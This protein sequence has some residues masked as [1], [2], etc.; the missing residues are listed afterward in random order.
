MAVTPLE[1]QT[2]RGQDAEPWRQLATHYAE[3]GWL[4]E[5][6][7]A[8]RRAL[9][10]QPDH[11]AARTELVEILLA[12]G[13][14]YSAQQV[15]R[16]AAAA[17]GAERVWRARLDQLQAQ[18][19]V[20]R[21]T[22]VAPAYRCEDTLE[23]CLRAMQAQT[24]PVHELFVVDD[25]SPDRSAEIAR[26]LGVR[27]VAHTENRGLAATCNTALGQAS[28]E[29]LAKL[30]S[31][32]ELSPVWLERAMLAFD[33]PSVAGVGGCVTERYASTVPDRWRRVFMPQQ[34]GPRRLDDAP[35][36]FGADCIYRVAALQ[37]VG[38]WNTRYRNNFE[39]MDLSRRLK[40]AGYR[41][42]YEP[43]ARARHLRRD[44]LPDV[45]NN[46]W[47][48]YHAPA[49]DQGGYDSLT[50]AARLIARN[51]TLAEERLAHCLDHGSAA[52]LT[53][54]SFL[55]FYWLCLRDVRHVARRGRVSEEAASQ[56]G[57]GVFLLAREELGRAVALPPEVVERAVDDLK[58][59]AESA[60]GGPAE[61]A[62]GSPGLEASRPA[63]GP[64]PA[65]SGADA[66]Y[67]REFAR[68][69]FA[70]TLRPVHGV[71]LRVSVAALTA[72][73]RES[74]GSRPVV[75]FNPPVRREGARL[76]DEDAASR[77]LV[78]SRIEAAADRLLVSDCPRL[79]LAYAGNAI[80]PDE[81]TH[82]PM[83]DVIHAGEPDGV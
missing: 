59:C 18:W 53:Y 83:F 8:Y 24:Y 7:A 60:F 9:Q 43:L 6:E 27:V 40:A 72:E 80:A 3:R 42:V 26:G 64:T 75:W 70:R 39:D 10:F 36:L 15:L 46:F 73:E 77:W 81:E 13:L 68:A 62:A 32:I 12:Q 69:G 4:P 44:R 29:F 57:R 71:L 56:T 2:W 67:L 25:A 49:Q 34:W 76:P 50:H 45:L 31:D 33:D 48:W 47:S 21:V 11:D 63:A 61:L 17:G 52:E 37:A 66:D 23:R 14:P 55:M 58:A 38:G 74:V 30:D 51:R 41:L 22:L 54:L 82:Y 19:P 28:G 5:A 78:P 1:A 20:R 65:P 16:E 79:V 35:R